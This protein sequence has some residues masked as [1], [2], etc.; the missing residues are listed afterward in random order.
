M[1]IALF[2]LEKEGIYINNQV[3]EVFV[4]PDNKLLCIRPEALGKMNPYRQIRRFD[5]EAGGILIGRVLVEDGNYI[6]DDVSEPMPTDKRSRFRF[7]RKT[8][9]HQ[10]YFNA[11]WERENGRCF[12]LGEWHTH[13]ERVP[14]PSSIDRKDWNRLLN[15][16]YETGCLFFIIL[17]IDEIKVW[18]GYGEEPIVVEL[19]RRKTD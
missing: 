13:P 8:E 19:K 7:S 2:V 6:I 16:G 11:V 17:G 12:Y 10:E 5:K 18:Y 14:I 15:I 3:E 4:L 1:N 9:G